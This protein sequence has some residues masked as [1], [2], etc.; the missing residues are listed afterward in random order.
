MPWV[1]YGQKG[2]TKTSGSWQ[3]YGTKKKQDKKKA[4]IEESLKQAE[5]YQAEAEK[6]AGRVDMIEGIGKTLVRPFISL[7]EIPKN[8]YGSVAGKQ[9]T[10]GDVN[11]PGLG[12]VQSYQEEAKGVTGDILEGKKPIYSIL[13]PM[14]SAVIDTAGIGIG[15]SVANGVTKE[16]FK[17]TVKRLIPEGAA[18]GLGQGAVD[19]IDN[20]RTYG[21][22]AKDIAT[23][24]A[25]GAVGAPLFGVGFNV[26]GRAVSSL[27]SK[28]SGRATKAR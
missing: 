4:V 5:K 16:A 28:L 18:Y 19:S 3:P 21:E 8:V 1:S 17:Q 7:A 15:S 10:F 14:G 9:N 25:F 23:S 6:Y 2:G 20:G 26:I 12:K 22:K 27:G 11:V 24:T 13:K